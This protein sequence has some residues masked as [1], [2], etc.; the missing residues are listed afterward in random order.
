M[1][2]LRVRGCRV[3]S[4]LLFVV[5]LALLGGC[6]GPPGSRGRCDQAALRAAADATD[7]MLAGWRPDAGALPDYQL[8]V[9]GLHGACPT[10][11]AGFH[12]FLKNAVHPVPDVR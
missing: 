10:L 1:R 7:A 11:P 9:R 5:N 2:R 8:A 6:G 3:R 4:G 12:G